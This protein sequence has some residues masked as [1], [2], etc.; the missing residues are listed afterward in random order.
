MCGR[1]GEEV[2]D[3]DFDDMYDRMHGYPPAGSFS[4][5]PALQ[6]E[7]RE[8]L[9]KLIILGVYSTS[10]MLL[11]RADSCCLTSDYLMSTPDRLGSFGGV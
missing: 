7:F 3:D 10:R 2:D 5:T 6:Q 11:P 8:E 9:E 4:W 1:T